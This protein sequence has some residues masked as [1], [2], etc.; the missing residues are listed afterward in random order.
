M[1]IAACTKHNVSKCCCHQ[2]A[3]AYL[4]KAVPSIAMIHIDKVQYLDNIAL[5][6]KVLTHRLVQFAFRIGHD[7]TFITTRSLQNKVTAHTS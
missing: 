6:T 3:I 5:V 7:D 1:I 4:G 2:F